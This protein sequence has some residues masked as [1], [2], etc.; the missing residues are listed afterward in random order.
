MKATESQEQIAL[1]QWAAMQDNKYPELKL[2]YHIPNGGQRNI[3]T[4]TRLKRE[5]VKSGVPDIFL[6]VV[7]KCY[8][9]LYI[10][11]KAIKGKTSKNQIEWIENLKFQGY[12]VV[13]C[14]GWEEAKRVI[15]R[16]LK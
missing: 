7:K 13:V 8:S 6:P 9:G 15:E 2:M 14:Y 5:G 12:A 3:V 16:Y 1:F 4:A 10:E 11:M